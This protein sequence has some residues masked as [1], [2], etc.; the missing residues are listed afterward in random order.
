M[1]DLPWDKAKQRDWIA[2]NKRLEQESF[3]QSLPY[4]LP[5][6][7]GIVL[8]LAIIFEVIFL[9]FTLQPYILTA[10][11]IVSFIGVP[12]FIYV[13]KRRDFTAVLQPGFHAWFTQ[14]GVEAT[15]TVIDCEARIDKDGDLMHWLEFVWHH[16]ETQ[17]R[18]TRRVSTSKA[19]YVAC[20]LKSTHPVLFDPVHPTICQFYRSQVKVTEIIAGYLE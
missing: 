14:Y 5:F 2:L 7:F 16:P 6:P 4:L 13:I 19:N 12:I 1:F 3:L 15:A 10:T 17:Q 8:G 18:Y 9:P 20:P 11:F